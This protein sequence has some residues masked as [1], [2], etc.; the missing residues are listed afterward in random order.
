MHRSARGPRP[1]TF[2]GSPSLATSGDPTAAKELLVD[3]LRG[4]AVDKLK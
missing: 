3:A 4:V 1:V 2:A